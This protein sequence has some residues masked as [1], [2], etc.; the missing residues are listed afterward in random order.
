MRHSEHTARPNRHSL[1]QVACP[2]GHRERS[3]FGS[4]PASPPSSRRSTRKTRKYQFTEKTLAIVLTCS[5]LPVLAAIAE[6][7][8]VFPTSAA[9]F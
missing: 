9:G 5:V 7:I 3:C 6:G 2:P 1:P 8:R 4:V